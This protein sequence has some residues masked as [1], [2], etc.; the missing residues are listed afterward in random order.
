MRWCWF[1]RFRPMRI[2]V[3]PAQSSLSWRCLVG[4][5]M[6]YVAA[7]GPS[8]SLYFSTLSRCE[9]KISGAWRKTGFALNRL[10]S[11]ASIILDTMGSGADGITINHDNK[12]GTNAR[13]RNPSQWARIKAKMEL[14]LVLFCCKFS[15]TPR[16]GLKNT[17]LLIY[18]GY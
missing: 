17:K 15:Q 4:F 16:Q 18:K 2:F 14:P 7:I 6:I 3:F 5:I 9:N 11:V 13:T 1:C 12:T 8:K 10:F